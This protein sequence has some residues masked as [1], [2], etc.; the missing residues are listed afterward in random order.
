MCRQAKMKQ[1]LMNRKR[2]TPYIFKHRPQ[3]VL[4]RGLA[5]AADIETVWAAVLHKNKE[6]SNDAS[7]SELISR[8]K[9]P[10]SPQLGTG[11]MLGVILAKI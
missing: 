9:R 4:L 5:L 11:A 1:K 6:T 3:L 10:I 2:N 8:S 7:L